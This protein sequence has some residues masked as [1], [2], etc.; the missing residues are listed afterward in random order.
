MEE[1]LLTETGTKNSNRQIPKLNKTGKNNVNVEI[2]R[3][4]Q[5][6]D[7]Y[8]VKAGETAKGLLLS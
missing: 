2:K 6:S 3:N 5:L 7:L 4:R 8:G 1:T